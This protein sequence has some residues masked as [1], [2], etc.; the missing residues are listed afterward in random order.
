MRIHGG[1]IAIPGGPYGVGAAG[2]PPFDGNFAG[3]LP[4]AYQVVQADRGLTYGGLMRLT[5]GD[6]SGTVVTLGGA[7]ATPPVPIMV[8]ATNTASVGAGATFNVYYD[9]LGVTPAMVGLTPTG[10]A[11]IALT[12]AAAGL[13]LTWTAD[14]SVTGNTWKAT[15]AA[16]ADQSGNGWHCSHSVPSQQPVV[17]AGLNGSVGLAFEATQSLGSLLSLPK[18]S[19][20]PFCIFAVLRRT[21]GHSYGRF[22]ANPANSNLLLLDGTGTNI[23]THNAGIFGSQQPMPLAQWVAVDCLFSGSV[24]DY[25]R[26]GSLPAASGLAAGDS[27]G[28]QVAIGDYFAGQQN[29]FD[30]LMLAHVPQTSAAAWRA[31]VTSKYGPT[32]QV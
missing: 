4:G 11:F 28:S 7:L 21:F 13:N 20:A 16:L 25:I 5:A 17:T 15:C 26:C 22:T 2:P 1:G 18:P 27:A 3:L 12:G 9:G 31:A 23:T 29:N 30:L 19:T 6:I 32:V 14:P 10:G 8:K 24:A